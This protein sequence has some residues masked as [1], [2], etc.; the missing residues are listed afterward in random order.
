M[1]INRR[2]AKHWVRN[3][4]SNRWHESMGLCHNGYCALRSG[5]YGLCG[6]HRENFLMW[7]KDRGYENTTFKQRII[8]MSTTIRQ[9]IREV[10]RSKED[11]LLMKHGVLSDNGNLT[12]QGRRIQGD[13]IF[14][15]VAL[16]DI[17]E[18]MVELV[19][20]VEDEEKGALA[21]STKSKK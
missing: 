7:C 5:K 20:A 18:K 1:R 9:K 3:H 12:E 4:Q 21:S 8:N 6:Y 13:L 14:N 16:A 11:R 15:G 17:K 10:M 19:Q 2:L